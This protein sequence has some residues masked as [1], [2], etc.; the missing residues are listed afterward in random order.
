MEETQGLI[1]DIL[2][3]ECVKHTV[4]QYKPKLS[5]LKAENCDQERLDKLPSAH[6]L[7]PRGKRLGHGTVIGG[8]ITRMVVL[9]FQSHVVSALC[10]AEIILF[11]RC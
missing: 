9:M 2:D 1:M 5:I 7:L 6:L 8:K 3:M 4:N 11:C 10:S